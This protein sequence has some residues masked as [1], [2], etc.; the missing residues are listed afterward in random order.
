MLMQKKYGIPGGG[1]SGVTADGVFFTNLQGI[2][3]AFDALAEARE[4]QDIIGPYVEECMST[5][6]RVKQRSIR[7]RWLI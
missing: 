6:H 5:A 4:L 3:D 7:Y 2:I 1:D